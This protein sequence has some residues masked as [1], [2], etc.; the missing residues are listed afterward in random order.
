M[1]AE[2]G[3]VG[4]DLLGENL[5]FILD[6][7]MMVRWT[8]T[9]DGVIQVVTK[10]VSS[11]LGMLLPLSFLL[12]SLT[13]PG[14]CPPS[15]SPRHLFYLDFWSLCSLLFS[16]QPDQTSTH[17]TSIQTLLSQTFKVL[18]FLEHLNISASV[19]SVTVPS[20]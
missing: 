16:L 1:W 14:S 3:P 18:L 15:F 5:A 4:P 13:H 8:V 20:M 19:L 12:L 2:P 17:N 10:P 6:V 9:S 11:P 7:C